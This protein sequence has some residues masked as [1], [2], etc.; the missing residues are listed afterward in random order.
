MLR[1]LGGIAKFPEN[2]D[3]TSPGN[4]RWQRRHHLES[5]PL[6]LFKANKPG[7]REFVE[8]KGRAGTEMHKLSRDEEKQKAEA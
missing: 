2:A 5:R 1:L 8:S 4:L 6:A 7:F 3:K